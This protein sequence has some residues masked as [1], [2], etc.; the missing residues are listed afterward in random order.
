MYGVPIEKTAILYTK[1]KFLPTLHILRV[2]KRISKQ[3]QLV[4]SQISVETKSNFNHIPKSADNWVCD[5]NWVSHP[6][7]L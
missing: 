1:Q 4:T 7:F 5:D 6:S 3:Q 2:E